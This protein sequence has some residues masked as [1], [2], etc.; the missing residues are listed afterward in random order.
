MVSLEC[1]DCLKK[2]HTNTASVTKYIYAISQYFSFRF[3]INSGPL[4][5]EG[6]NLKHIYN[7]EARKNTKNEQRQTANGRGMGEQQY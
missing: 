2:T 7:K 1:F 4:I 3:L 6:Y 5:M